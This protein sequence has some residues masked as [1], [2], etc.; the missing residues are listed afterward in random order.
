MNL[1]SSTPRAFVESAAKALGLWRN[2]TVDYAE[3]A[4]R[5]GVKE[6]TLRKV[7]YGDIAL[8]KRIESGIKFMVMSHQLAGSTGVVLEGASIYDPNA[9][10]PLQAVRSVRVLSMAQAGIATNYDEL[11]KDWQE[12]INTNVRDE[13]AFSVRIRGDSMEPRYQE[14]DYIIVSPSLEP[15][16]GDLV[17]AKLSDDGVAFKLV[18]FGR[19]DEVVLTSYNPIYPPMRYSKADFH[20]IFP[21]AEVTKRVLRR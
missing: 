1:D 13:M 18:Q 11:P 2:D 21:V 20:W 12:E 14:G 5:V 17:L 3:F 15:R 8:S 16:S 9:S 6:Q 19:D 7:V 10:A 4:R